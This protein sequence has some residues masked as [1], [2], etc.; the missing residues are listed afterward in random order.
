M[1]DLIVIYLKY[2]SYLEIHIHYNADTEILG[3]KE[4][5]KGQQAS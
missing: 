5:N 2:A 4:T 1:S 3:D